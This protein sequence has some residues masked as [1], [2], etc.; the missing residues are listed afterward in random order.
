M[1]QEL[2]K[3]DFLSHLQEPRWSFVH[4][5]VYG[6]PGH[7]DMVTLA[8]FSCSM[9]CSTCGFDCQSAIITYPE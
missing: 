2:V 4:G 9:L 8:I 6:W 1:G 3:S 5:C 7:Q